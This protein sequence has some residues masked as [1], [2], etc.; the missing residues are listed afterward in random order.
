MNVIE[1]E[2]VKGTLPASPAT[3]YWGPR[4][5]LFFLSGLLSSFA[6]IRVCRASYHVAHVGIEIHSALRG[7]V[8]L[9]RSLA[10]SLPS[11]LPPS[12]ME[13][14]VDPSIHLRCGRWDGM[15]RP[16]DDGSARIASILDPKLIN[17]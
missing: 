1:D 4:K 8:T 7:P 5:Q 6:A 16:E 13:T 10:L 14:S 3:S 17:F 15:E 12:P 2:V 9:P 11:A